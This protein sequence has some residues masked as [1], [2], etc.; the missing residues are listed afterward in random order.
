MDDK[1]FFSINL[2]VRKGSAMAVLGIVVILAVIYYLTEWPRPI[3]LGS[4]SFPE[5]VIVSHEETSTRVWYSGN[6]PRS[7]TYIWQKQFIVGLLCCEELNS[8][9][10]IFAFLDNWLSA[11]GWV[12]WHEVGSPCANMA[13]TEFLER[14]TGY[15]PYV[16]KGTTNLANSPSVCVAVWPWTDSAFSVLLLTAN[17]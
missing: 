4:P 14:G 8:P 1:E 3:V 10:K 16:P 5:G 12:Q 2:K 11:M 13:E 6:N 9:E 17:K 7:K 15:V